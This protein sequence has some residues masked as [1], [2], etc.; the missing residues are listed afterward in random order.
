MP[1][2]AFIEAFNGRF[3]AECLNAHWFLSLVDATEKLETWR[4]DYNAQRPHGSIGNK[5]PAELMKSGHAT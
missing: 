2:N 5:V 4:R 3:R 1:D